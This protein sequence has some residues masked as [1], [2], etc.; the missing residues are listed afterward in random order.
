MRTTEP[1]RAISAS[2][3]IVNRVAN[4]EGVEATELTP[5]YTAIDPDALDALVGGHGRSASSLKIEFS[6]Q[7][8]DVTVTGE[9]VIHLDG[10]APA[11]P[12]DA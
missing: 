3:A 2:N 12:A 6:Y 10:A 1:V 11:Q 5:L 7:G 8:Y 4:A 9:G